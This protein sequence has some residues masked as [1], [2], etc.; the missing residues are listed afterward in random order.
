MGGML[1][2]YLNSLQLANCHIAHP[3][4]YRNPFHPILRGYSLYS[5]VEVLARGTV[6]LHR[7]PIIDEDRKLINVITQSQL[8][9]FVAKNLHLLGSKK[10]KRVADMPNV[11]HDVEKVLDSDL[12]MEAFKKMYTKVCESTLKIL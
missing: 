12:A 10:N 3:Q 1:I 4:G 6:N 5:A 9:S 7:V 11:F 2:I 8:V